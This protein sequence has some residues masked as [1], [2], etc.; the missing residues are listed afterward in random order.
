M[1]KLEATVQAII[2]GFLVHIKQNLQA[3]EKLRKAVPEEAFLV[4]K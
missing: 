3:E 1:G 4:D 2:L